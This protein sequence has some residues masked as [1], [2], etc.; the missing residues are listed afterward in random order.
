MAGHDRRPQ[1]FTEA[2]APLGDRY[3][4]HERFAPG[5]QNQKRLEQPQGD[6]RGM[7]VMA[8]LSQAEWY[9]AAFT[10]MAG[11][12]AIERCEDAPKPNDEKEPGLSTKRSQACR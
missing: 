3:T 8:R 5:R 12:A 10:Y 7:A 11:S 2:S 1:N 6:T 4:S 9:R